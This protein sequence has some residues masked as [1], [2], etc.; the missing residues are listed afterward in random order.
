MNISPVS[1]NIHRYPAYGP[2][3]RGNNGVS[4]VSQSKAASNIRVISFKGG[5]KNQALFYGVEVRPYFAKGGVSTIFQDMRNLKISEGAPSFNTEDAQ[6]TKEY[7]NQADKVFVSPVYNGKDV[8]NYDKGTIE[9]VQLDKIPD[10]LPEGSPFAKYKGKYFMTN[11]PKYKEYTTS[12]GFFAKENLKLDKD[13]FI[14]DDVTGGE[15]KMDFGASEDVEIKLFRVLKKFDGSDE[16]QKTRDFLVF[17]D[18]TTT[19]KAPYEGGG[20]AS[21]SGNLVQTWKGDGDARSAKAFTE[22]MERICEVAS[23]DGVKFDPATLVLNDSQSANAAEYIAEKASKG[24]EFW[25]GKKPFFITHNSG[26]GYIQKTTALN[27]FMNIADRE[28]INAVEKDPQ[29][30]EA[31]K[32]GEQAVNGYFAMKMPEEMADAQS[33]FS[34]FRNALYYAEKGYIPVGTVSPGYHKAL[35]SNPDLAPGAYESLKALAEKGDFVGILNAFEGFGMDPFSKSGVNGY[36]DAKKD[37]VYTFPEEAG[38]LAGKEIKAFSV[39]DK[40]KVNSDGIDIAHV[41][42]IKRQNKVKLL[43]RLDKQT[44]KVLKDLQDVEGHKTDFNK[45]VAGLDGKDVKVYGYIYP[46]FVEEAIKPESDIKVITSWG[47]GDAQKGLD[48]VLA[49][50]EKY[51]MKFGDK[52]PNTVLVMG[53]ALDLDK[54]E[55]N[56]EGKKIKEVI[57]RMH[58]NPKLKGRFVYLDGF[59]PNKPLAAAADFSVFPSRFAP[60]ELT[61]LESYKLLCSP[62]VTNCQGLADKNFDASF[63]GEAEK[64]TGYKTKHAYDMPLEELTKNIEELDKVEKSKAN[65]AA[66]ERDVKKFFD[67]IKQEQLI[68]RNKELTDEEVVEII[69]KSADLHRQYEY[70][71]LRPYRDR[72]IENELVDCFERALITERNSEVQEKMIHNLFNARTDWEGNAAL[73]GG[74]SSGAAYREIFHRDVGTIK[75]EDTLLYKIKQKCKDIIENARKSEVKEPTVTTGG[76]KGGNKWLT[77]GAVAVGVLGLG[78]GIISGSKNSKS[79][80]KVEESSSEADYDDEA[81]YEKDEE[82]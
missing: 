63:E 5:N 36:Y 62:I 55:G 61:D 74:K 69:K 35:I 13:I 71:V 60:C 27:M 28:L 65:K 78:Y 82:V 64:V 54:K 30:I 38:D 10:N 12:E 43:E 7:W 39:M 49:A 46:Q 14:L 25:N 23:E 2:S 34:P 52:D 19:W 26:A 4:D 6:K 29:F 56:E 40:A 45:V 73:N 50:F 79:A 53:G 67:K 72:V 22:L 44:L 66:L 16:L 57:D 51:I 9:K 8:Y 37:V 21:G 70:E 59:A 81:D 3:V 77:I 1:S 17:S 11:S 41:R 76:A 31:L 24:S 33:A 15:R 32:Q 68:K 80:S 75:E 47:R 42:E 18:V 48:S 20:Y 58:A